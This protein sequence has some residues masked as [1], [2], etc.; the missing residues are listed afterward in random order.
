M[1]K[2]API[3]GHR[4]WKCVITTHNVRIPV[5]PSIYTLLSV[6]HFFPRARHSV[7]DKLFPTSA[8]LQGLIVTK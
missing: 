5:H 1:R 7:L 2:E 6:L 8:R 4:K 3:W